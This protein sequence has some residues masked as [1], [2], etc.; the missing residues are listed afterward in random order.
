MKL[1]HSMVFSTF[2][3]VNAPQEVERA[4]EQ[5]IGR[6]TRLFTGAGPQCYPVLRTI[7]AQARF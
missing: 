2:C 5:G 6:Y 1:H 4:S 7:P 3:A